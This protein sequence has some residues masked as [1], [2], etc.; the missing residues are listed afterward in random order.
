MLAAKLGSS[1][2]FTGP[3]AVFAA[4]AEEVK[5]YQGI[6]FDAIGPQGVVWGGDSLKVAKKNVVPVDGA[7]AVA[8]KYV[9][10][11][12]STLSH[13]GTVSTHAKGPVAV[14]PEAYLEFG[15]EDAAAL[16]VAEGDT[17]KVKADGA[18]IELVA[19]VD[20]RLPQGVVFAPY[21]FADAGLNKLYKGEAAVAVEV[22]K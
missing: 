5:D 10:L 2:S 21:H 4:V 16:K 19:K 12:G 11:T 22:S 3:A 20:N 15:R 18:E 13:S 8:G 6:D 14:V 7:D 9:L 1:L 17:I